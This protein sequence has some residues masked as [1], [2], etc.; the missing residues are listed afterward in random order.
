MN[1][2]PQNF[3]I[4]LV[5]FFSI[6]LSGTLLTWLLLGEVD[7]VVLGDRYANLAGE[8][9]RAA[10]L[11]AS[12][13]FGHQVFPLGSRQDEFHD[14][15]RRYPLNTQV[16]ALRITVSALGP[17]RAYWGTEPV[18]IADMIRIS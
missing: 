8:E 3:W 6:L 16:A 7:P 11:F 1:F 17:P 4:G 2:E 5:D 12:Y 14:R 10:V 9:S 15:A 18:V 13:F